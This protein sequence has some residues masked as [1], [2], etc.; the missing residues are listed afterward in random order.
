LRLYLF[1]FREYDRPEYGRYNEHDGQDS[2]DEGPEPEKPPPP[3][4]S[5]RDK[6]G[7][8]QRESPSK[9]PEN[10]QS[11]SSQKDPFDESPSDGRKEHR[12]DRRPDRWE[13][14]LDKEDR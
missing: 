10:W 3:R 13:R 7:R 1:T 12:E 2:G 11:P 14:D 6:G 5:P 9:A 4:E 8:Q